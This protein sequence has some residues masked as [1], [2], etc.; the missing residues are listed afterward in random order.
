[1]ERDLKRCCADCRREL[2]L[3]SFHRASKDVLGRQRSCKECSAA[4]YRAWYAS[5]IQRQRERSLSNYRKNVDE[6]RAKQR[7]YQK[8]DPE[9][10]RARHR[11]WLELVPTRNAERVAKRRAAA[12]AQSAGPVDFA[13]ILKRDGDICYLCGERPKK[14]HFD[15]VIPLSKGG[16]HSMENIK[17]ACSTCNLKKGARILPLAA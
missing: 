16:A 7:E 3:E 8:R 4:R 13:E 5:N 14:R 1:M 9:L 10:R 11:A 12:L 2:S 15:H 6:R 17:V